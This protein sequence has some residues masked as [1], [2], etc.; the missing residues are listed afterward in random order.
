MRTIKPMN[1][2]SLYLFERG[3]FIMKRLGFKVLSCISNLD[4]TVSVEWIKTKKDNK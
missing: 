3:S 2:G 4:G 1:Y